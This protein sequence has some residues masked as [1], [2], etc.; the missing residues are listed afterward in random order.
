[1]G[2]ASFSARVSIELLERARDV[3]AHHQGD[4]LYLTLSELTN[5]VLRRQ[6]RR[7]KREHGE[8]PK[9][10]EG[11]QAGIQGR[12]KRKKGSRKPPRRTVLCTK[13]DEELR[14]AWRD[15]AYLRREDRELA[16]LFEEGLKK[17]I[18]AL[19]R[20][21]GPIEERSAARTTLRPGRR[22]K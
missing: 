20:K 12:R 4:P 3:V 19:E 10:P 2:K 16:E 5:R 1:M 15:Y 7:A 18:K 17:E 14:E 21:Y 9:R 11:Q 13:V 22:I 6:V 8:I